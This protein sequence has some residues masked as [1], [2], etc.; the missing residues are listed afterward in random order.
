LPAVTSVINL[1]QVR[2][3]MAQL[4]NLDNLSLSGSLVTVDRRALSGI[5]TVLK[6]RFGGKLIICG[7]YYVDEDAP[8]NSTDRI[9]NTNLE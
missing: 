7:E 2:D 1:V 8:T 5:G 6:G 3:V 9:R 4:P